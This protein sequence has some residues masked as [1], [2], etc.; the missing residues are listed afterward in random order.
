MQVNVEAE[1][2]KGNYGI[3]QVISLISAMGFYSPASSFKGLRSYQLA[4]DKMIAIHIEHNWR[5]I[6]FQSLGADFLTN[7]DLD[8][9]TGA[10]ALRIF[11]NSNY[12]PQLTQKNLYWEVYAGISRILGLINLQ[13][14][15]NSF[16]NYSVTFSIAP[17]F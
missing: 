12:L 9:I 8:I 4:G 11:N 14:S 1:Y 7:S 6:L 17:F 16:K 10:A 15:Y 2:I 5:T 13:L 3:Q